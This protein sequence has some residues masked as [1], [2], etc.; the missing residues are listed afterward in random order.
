MP[1]PATVRVKISTEAADTI[2]LTPVVTRDIPFAELF[3]SIVAITGKQP[4]RVCE[5]IARGSLV[6]GGSR[7]RWQGWPASPD[8]VGRLL[9]AFPDPE[10]SRPFDP[11]SCTKAVLRAPLG[12]I[13]ITRE[14]GAR[15]RFLRRSSFWDALLALAARMPGP[16][17]VE[18]SYRERAD[19]YRLPL[20]AAQRATLVESAGLLVYSALAAQIARQPAESVDFLTPR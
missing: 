14:T 17:Y 4:D 12:S 16:R 10:P 2:S 7:L 9:A 5:L 6:S 15:R 11:A 8:D 20:A 19:R 3:D 1:L 13:E 18:Y